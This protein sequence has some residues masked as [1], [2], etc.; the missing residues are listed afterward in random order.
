MITDSV[1]KVIGDS[2]PAPN[3]TAAIT[4][5]DPTVATSSHSM[6]LDR[7]TGLAIA[8]L[9]LTAAGNFRVAIHVDGAEASG[10]PADVAVVP[11]PPHAAASVFDVSQNVLQAGEGVTVGAALFDVYDNAVVT[12][13]AFIQCA[14][15]PCIH[16]VSL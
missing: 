12:G 5:S 15:H 14:S 16:L 3:V 2:Q 9:H 6:L 11:A 7:T 10:S 8:Q 13:G 1:L 4:P